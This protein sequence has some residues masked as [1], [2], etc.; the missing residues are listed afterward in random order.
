MSDDRRNITHLV[1]H[2][3]ATPAKTTTHDGV[4]KYHIETNGW[5]DIGYH[6]TIDHKGIV[7]R[8]REDRTIGAHA[9]GANSYSLGIC[10]FGNFNTEHPTAEQIEVLIKLLRNLQET[11]SI[12]AGNIIGHRD[13]GKTECC[14]NNLY[15]LLPWIRTNLSI[16]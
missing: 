15:G 7:N 4:K 3:S 2:H 14:G 11:Y 13:V 1:I 12:P 9:R 6:Y 8:G 10:L 5:S 16:C